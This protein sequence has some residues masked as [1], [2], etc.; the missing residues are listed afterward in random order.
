[1]E[2]I[3]AKER[4]RRVSLLRGLLGLREVA[5]N[6]PMPPE[7]AIVSCAI[8]L[9]EYE[10]RPADIAAIA[11]LTHLP[12]EA[13]EERIKVLADVGLLENPEEGS[14]SAGSLTLLP[15]NPIVAAFYSSTTRAKTAQRPS[16]PRRQCYPFLR[17]LWV[18]INRRYVWRQ[19]A[20]ILGQLLHFQFA[21]YV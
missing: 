6:L 10:G 21:D 3:S 4:S 2:E 9:C 20:A 5:A 1:M 19:P 7:V 15:E 12:R 17:G 16:F 18:G 11:E 13:V 14:V 8:R